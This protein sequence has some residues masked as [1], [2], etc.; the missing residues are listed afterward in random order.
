MFSVKEVTRSGIS[1]PLG[2]MRAGTTFMF[3][4]SESPHIR[5]STN[6]ELKGCKGMVAVV[7]LDSGLLYPMPATSWVYLIDIEGSVTFIDKW[8]EC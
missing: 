6:Y 2:S 3:Q 4:G 1:R 7:C 8:S 5:V